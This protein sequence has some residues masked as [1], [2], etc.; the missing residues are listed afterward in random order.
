[1]E[2]AHSIQEILDDGSVLTVR[3][4]DL[5]DRDV[6][7]LPLQC[8]LTIPQFPGWKAPFWEGLLELGRPVHLAM[9]PIQ[10]PGDATSAPAPHS[11]VFSHWGRAALLFARVYS[12]RG[13]DAR[14]DDPLS[15]LA[16]RRLLPYFIKAPGDWKL[17]DSVQAG[18][19]VARAVLATD[20]DWTGKAQAED[21]L[22]KAFLA[23]L[24]PL[25]RFTKWWP[26]PSPDHPED[27]A[28]AK[29]RRYPPP[30]ASEDRTMLAMDAVR[31]AILESLQSPD[32]EDV[33]ASCQQRWRDSQSDP[34]ALW[35][36]WL[37]G[38]AAPNAILGLGLAVWNLRVRP[39]LVRSESQFHVS[40]TLHNDS[41]Y[42]KLPKLT[43]GFAWAMGG[44][45]QRLTGT[46]HNGERY[47]L[48]PGVAEGVTTGLVPGTAALIAKIDGHEKRPHQTFLALDLDE[49]PQPLAAELVGATSY[50]V[51]TGPDAKL[52]ILTLAS[53][54]VK[55]G[56]SFSLSLGE[57]AAEL[58]PGVRIQATHLESASKAAR[59]LRRVCLH[60]PDHRQL[61]VFDN[62]ATAHDR[63]TPDVMVSLGLGARL[64]EV[65]ARGIPGH[66]AYFGEFLINLDGAMRLD[67][68]HPALLRHYIRAAAGW[69]SA[70]APGTGEFSE[71]MLPAYT[72]TTWAALTNSLP[73]GA[74]RAGSSNALKNAQSKVRD[75]LKRLE[76]DH[77]L[78]RVKELPARE[79]KVLP[80]GDLN[81]AWKK[82]RNEGAR[83]LPAPSG[84]R[85]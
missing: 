4:E 39:D 42:S 69:N 32:V 80:P 59:H 7:A 63:A 70:R 43:S 50:G 26:Y 77:G 85:R 68:R 11:P 46:D 24:A 17:V 19:E 53:D 20:A 73:L 48:E 54:D 51:L 76:R 16:R 8:I 29:H 57:L 78:L 79:F 61:Q 75:E 9:V 72:S 15:V 35:E 62:V 37:A 56:G 31:I 84:K 71:K 60:L 81:E 21:A 13:R 1:M 44:T 18:R 5:R 82:I 41:R 65:L 58:Y 23:V 67:S 28:R 27:S 14:T 40:G 22:A 83:R 36:P 25:E 30:I 55:R 10:E 6:V 34:V 45:G 2:E 64:V 74:V 12:V 52:A 49:E 38:D 47:R 66:S 3:W 33:R